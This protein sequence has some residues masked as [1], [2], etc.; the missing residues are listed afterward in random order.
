LLYAF[1]GGM[2]ELNQHN[3]E[4]MR[5]PLIVGV[6]PAGSELYRFRVFG[7]ADCEF[8]PAEIHATLR[9][10]AHWLSHGRMRL[11]EPSTPTLRLV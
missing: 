11:L 7:N 2:T 1:G 4:R 6:R 8:P 9:G 5:R 10:L 3:S